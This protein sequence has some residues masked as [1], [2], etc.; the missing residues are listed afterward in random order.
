MADAVK[1]EIMSAAQIHLVVATL[2]I[3]VTFAAGFTLPGGFDSD[4]NSPNKGMAILIRKTAF[5]AFVVSDVIAFMCSAGAVFTYFAM[6]DYN[7]VTVQDSVL[8]KLYD[9]AGLLQHLALISVVIA[10]VTGMYATLAHSLGLA[11][12]VVV[13]G[14][15]SFFVYL[16]V[17][18]KI[19]LS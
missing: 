17:F 14:C 2:L 16:W 4:P 11:I 13:I 3:T 5:R 9:V 6:A 19:A 1:N 12:T 8:E 7:R 15:I 18:F 10:F